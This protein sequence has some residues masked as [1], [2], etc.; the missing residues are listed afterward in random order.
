M[1]LQSENHN[2]VFR[3]VII[4]CAMFGFGFAM[5]PLYD[6]FCDITGINGKTNETAVV[7]SAP[8]IDTS[9]EVAV[10]FITRTHKGMPWE[11]SATTQ[12]IV[13]HPG[14]L[15]TVEFYVRN[16]ARRD[17]VAQAIPSVSPGTAALYLNKTEC[18][19]FN[20][21]PLAAG[22]EALMP[23]QFY[24]DPQIPDDVT[25][26]TVQYTLF[27]VTARA[28]DPKSLDNP[29]LSGSNAE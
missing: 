26:F 4:T 16:P 13:V 7:Y 9:R 14:E 12:R 21:Q 10:E 22:E 27:D 18:F 6:V 25:V 3:L 15:N 5:V 23:M 29:F 19:C 11:F 8:E 17:I 28:D 2:M 24:V 1:A 20:H